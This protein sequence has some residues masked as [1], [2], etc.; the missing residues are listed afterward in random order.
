[1]SGCHELGCGVLEIEAMYMKQNTA[2]MSLSCL[3]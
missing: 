1:M 2:F 3:V